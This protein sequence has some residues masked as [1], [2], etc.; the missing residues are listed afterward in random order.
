MEGG[1]C[2]KLGS[3]FGAASIRL[4]SLQQLQGWRADRVQNGAL[5]L[6]PHARACLKKYIFS[7]DVKMQWLSPSGTILD[8]GEDKKE[9]GGGVARHPGGLQGHRGRLGPLRIT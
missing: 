8:L 6:A 5:A 3:R 4:N 9:E 7:N 1:C 2:S